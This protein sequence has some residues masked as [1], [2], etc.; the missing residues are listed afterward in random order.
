MSEKIKLSIYSGK[1]PKTFKVIDTT[2]CFVGSDGYFV[3]RGNDDKSEIQ[4]RIHS[5][6]MIVMRI[7]FSNEYKASTFMLNIK[8]RHKNF[9]RFTGER[10]N[11]NG[12]VGDKTVGAVVRV[13]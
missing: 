2:E 13:L 12:T 7:D 6:G 3:G 5:R 1:S 8:E 4:G 11:I 9:R 10:K